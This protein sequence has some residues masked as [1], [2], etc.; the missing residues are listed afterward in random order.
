M[1][2]ASQ[3]SSFDADNANYLEYRTV[4]FMAISASILAVMSLAGFLFIPLLVLSLAGMVCAIVAMRRIA[5]RP[6]E[7]SGRGLAVGSLVLSAITFIG[8]VALHSVVYATEVP[9]GYRRI[10]FAE[11]QP[12]PQHPELPIPPSANE[13]DG[14]QVFVKG[15]IYP[16][17][18]KS[19]IKRFILI[20]DLGTCCFGGQ[21]ALTDMI[22]VT[23]NDPMRTRYNMQRRRVTGV[24]KVDHRKKPVSGVDGVYYQM[25]ADN[26][27]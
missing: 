10:S 25:H 9:H 8:G 19:G 18:Q 13:L 11:L 26:I 17:G 7:L 22:E 20:P 6:L 23:L 4:S 3:L 5:R 14:E 2:A 16:D 12:D 15:Y 1:S 21:P 24:L 27:Y